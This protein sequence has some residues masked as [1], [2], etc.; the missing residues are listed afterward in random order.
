[1]NEII[2][3]KPLMGAGVA[4]LGGVQGHEKLYVVGT[5][6]VLLYHGNDNSARE[7]ALRLWLRRKNRE[8][9]AG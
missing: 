1:M 8:P 2:P 4:T 3:K 7:Q 5:K 9:L 6:R